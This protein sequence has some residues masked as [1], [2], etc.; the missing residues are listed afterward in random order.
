MNRD[1]RSF[2][3]IIKDNARNE[4]PRAWR[5]LWNEEVDHALLS[6]GIVPAGLG[7]MIFFFV[8]ASLSL[9]F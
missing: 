1:Q 5:F 8:L 7:L 9:L 2:L 3:Q 4:A 6:V